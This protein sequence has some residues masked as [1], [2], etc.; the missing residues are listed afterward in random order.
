MPNLIKLLIRTPTA[1]VHGRVANTRHYAG[2]PKPD[3]THHDRHSAHKHH[4]IYTVK[5]DEGPTITWMA[6]IVDHVKR[7]VHKHAIPSNGGVP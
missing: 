3:G 6:D 5:A 7:S 1:E 2:E 4:A